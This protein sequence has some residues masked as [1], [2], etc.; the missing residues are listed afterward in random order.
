[1]STDR[2]REQLRPAPSSIASR[3]AT[4]ALAGGILGLFWWAAYAPS[5]LSAFVLVAS[6]ALAGLALGLLPGALFARWRSSRSERSDAAD[7][8]RR[9]RGTTHRP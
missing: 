3:A 1:M 5:V 7:R 4:G 8:R 9:T 2:T 6:H